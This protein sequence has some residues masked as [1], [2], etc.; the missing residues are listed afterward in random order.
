[1]C[2][3]ES[4]RAIKVAKS[5]LQNYAPLGHRHSMTP[6]V[7]LS[8]CTGLQ[9]PRCLEVV[10][11]VYN[12]LY[13]RFDN[14]T[15][16][17]LSTDEKVL[18]YVL[19]SPALL[20]AF[21]RLHATFQ[22]TSNASASHTPYIARLRAPDL[23]VTAFHENFLLTNRPV[24]VDGLTREWK[25]PLA[26]KQGGWLGDCGNILDLAYL[27]GRFGECRVPVEDEGGKL[28]YMRFEEFAGLW[29]SG[30]GCFYLKDWHVY[31]H[32]SELRKGAPTPDLFAEDWMNA[33]FE[34]QHMDYKFAYVGR[35]GTRTKLHC[36]IINS[37]SWST[38]VCGKK[39]WKLLP[40]EQTIW[41][42]DLFAQHMSKS[43]EVAAPSWQYPNL[44][45]CKPIE[46]VQDKGE[47]IFVPSGWYHTVENVQDTVSINANWFNGYNLEWVFRALQDL[48]R[49]EE[50]CAKRKEAGV[51][52]NEEA[53][54]FRVEDFIG[55]ISYKLKGME[56][57]NMD[58]INKIALAHIDSIIPRLTLIVRTPR[59]KEQVVG[60][61]NLL[62]HVK[63]RFSPI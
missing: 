7:P 27:R 31:L 5:L 13:A 35:R 1:M 2:S 9:Q 50:R 58:S 6:R 36:D 20:D 15:A 63:S 24:V 57:E 11:A 4:I 46:V 55:I 21:L 49:R 25:L 44:S 39:I 28:E 45:R 51:V 53:K 59:E 54:E 16:D 42:F 22:P 10:R 32:D 26:V 29:E 52:T 47:T 38:N 40:P 17:L 23:S 62:E 48:V 34:A 41:L 56:A 33:Y 3:R 18:V 14:A 37:Y 12:C 30:E 61:I 43:F 8:A 19:F 60:L